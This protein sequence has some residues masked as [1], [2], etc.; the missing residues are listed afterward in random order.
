MKKLIVMIA[1]MAMTAAA[2]SQFTSGFK[3]R[4]RA[5]IGT[6]GTGTSADYQTMKRKVD[7]RFRPW[8]NYQIND[9]V[10]FKTMFEIGDTNFG[11]GGAAMGT[12]GV[13][14][15]VKHVYLN[16]KPSKD[17]NLRLGLQYY[18]DMHN[19]I[20][21][22]DMAG[23]K[24]DRSFGAFGLGLGYFALADDGELNYNKETFGFGT[25]L[26][27]TDLG[28][29]INDKMSAG[30]TAVISL[31]AEAVAFDSTYMSNT[32]SHGTT[33]M[34]FA[35][36]FKGDFGMVKAELEFAYMMESYSYT[37][38]VD[39][40]DDAELSDTEDEGQNGFALSLKTKIKATEKVLVGVDF[41]MASGD[42]D[43]EDDNAVQNG[44]ET[45]AGGYY[46]NN[47]KIMDSDTYNF[48]NNYKAA[49]LMMPSLYA[50]YML[51]KKMTF[52]V[53][54]G[55]AMT[56]NEI[57]EDTNLGMEFGLNGKI[58]AFDGVI[59]APWANFFMPGQAYTGDKDADT[60]MQM[61]LG[62]AVKVKF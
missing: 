10:S 33:K 25:S 1:I 20:V 13:V 62:L 55:M 51:N 36:T 42:D 56:L 6:V 23:V 28:F 47:L 22:K 26:I 4:F 19:I 58:K 31:D 9:K 60:D 15:E 37:S 59:L 61:K 30:L 24:Y 40:V 5:V 57:A 2:F 7:F 46:L 35:P 27:T 32:Q 11:T 21:D 41:V 29:K 50:N 54:F 43:E 53:V 17:C 34:W 8:F 3:T 39:G 16:V 52:G 38:L 14:I 44:Y 45:L 18:G 48:F 49:G 12:D